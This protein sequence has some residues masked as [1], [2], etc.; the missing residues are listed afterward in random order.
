MYYIEYGT[1]SHVLEVPVIYISFH[2]IVK[3]CQ[4]LN[5]VLKKSTTARAHDMTLT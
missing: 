4:N 5:T 3:P 1:I 2:E